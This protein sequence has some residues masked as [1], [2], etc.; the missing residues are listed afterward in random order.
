MTY[1]EGS[2][3]VNR[4]LGRLAVKFVVLELVQPGVLKCLDGRQSRVD[5]LL[6]ELLNEVLCRVRDHFPH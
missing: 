3:G 2:K 6:H 1:L 5:I 4:F